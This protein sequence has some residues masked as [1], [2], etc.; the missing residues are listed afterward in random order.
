MLCVS[1][2]GCTWTRGDFFF[3]ALFF[4]NCLFGP[5]LQFK[6]GLSSLHSSKPTSN[7]R[8]L[9]SSRTQGRVVNLHFSC[10]MCFIP[11]DQSKYTLSWLLSCNLISLLFFLLFKPALL[12]NSLDRSAQCLIPIVVEKST[13]SL[14]LSAPSQYIGSVLSPCFNQ[15]SSSV[16]DTQ[17]HLR[18]QF[19]WMHFHCRK[20]IILC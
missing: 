12:W 7:Q 17:D 19:L 2:S 20:C 6:V 15:G 8:L 11:F 16:D 10:I 4:P 18:S 14:R 5:I 9:V 13:S 3:S 1:S